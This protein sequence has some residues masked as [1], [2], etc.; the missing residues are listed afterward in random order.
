MKIM[1]CAVLAGLAVLVVAG[2]AAGQSAQVKDT[3]EIERAVLAAHA[4]MT[5]AGEAV[6]ADRLFSFMLPTEKGSLIQNGVFFATREEALAAVK[7]SLQGLSRIEYTWKREHVSVLSPDVAL[8]TA[9]GQSSATT[10]DGRQIGAP[11]AQT[12]V[13]VRRDGA[14]KAIHA[15]QSS[16]RVR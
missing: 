6:D 9:E 8:L 7:G 3:R 5:R 15:H 10:T 13:F 14:W 2:P 1:R 4:E 11:F 16:P 12:I